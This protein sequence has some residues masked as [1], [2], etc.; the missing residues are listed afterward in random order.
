[1]LRG[2]VSLS[3]GYLDE[4]PLERCVGV[5]VLACRG[6]MDGVCVLTGV[7]EVGE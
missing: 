6:V 3:D 4:S 5:E 2:E 1:M 7:E